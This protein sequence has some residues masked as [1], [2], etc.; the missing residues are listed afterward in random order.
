MEGRRKNQVPVG[1][2]LMGRLDHLARRHLSPRRT[3]NKSEAAGESNNNASANQYG[4][5]SKKK[6]GKSIRIK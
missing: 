6:V 1:R 4:M 3:R 5:D 2:Q